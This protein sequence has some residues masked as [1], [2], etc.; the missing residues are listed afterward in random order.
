MMNSLLIFKKIKTTAGII[1]LIFGLSI[2][3]LGVMVTLSTLG[4]VEDSM[5]WFT[6]AAAILLKILDKAVT[7]FKPR[8]V[9]GEPSDKYIEKGR[10]GFAHIGSLVILALLSAWLLYGCTTR[11]VKG[12]H[13]EVF[14]KRGPPCKIKVTMDGDVIQES[15]ARKACIINLPVIEIPVEDEGI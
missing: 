14:V 2:V 6:A 5:A 7:T 9:K 13:L 8:K 3:V 1:G 11:L 15:E 4:V 10:K 12:D